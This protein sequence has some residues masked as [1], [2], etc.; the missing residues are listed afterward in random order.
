[1]KIE[2]VAV[3]A[4]R[5]IDPA[6][7]AIVPPIQ[8]S[9]TYQRD[10]DGGYSRSFSYTRPDNPTRHALETC[11]A[12]LEG[13]TEA[14]CF[15]SGAAATMAVF[16]LLNPGDHVLA[17]QECYY[18]TRQ[19]LRDYLSRSGVRA[20]FI[21]MSDPA[22]LEARLKPETRLIW[23]ETPCNPTLKL[24]DL[25]V[26][27]RC[28]HSVGALLVCDNTF[29]T[30]VLQQPLAAGA[31]AVVHSSTKYFGGHSDV[32]GGAVIVNDAARA[33]AVRAYQ[34]VGGAVPSPF[35]CWLIRR[36][37]A[38][39]PLRIRTQSA[40]ALE[41]AKFLHGHSRVERVCYPGLTDDPGH[42]LALRQ[43]TGFGAMVSVCVRGDARAAMAVAA[44]T[45]VFTC[46][47]SLGGV[48][49]L[50]EH[51]A[52]VE[53]PDTLTPQNLLR[54]SIGLENPQDLIEDLDQALKG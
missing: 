31:D 53:G 27:A 30:P 19:L 22:Q 16:S 4:G 23:I 44:R 40:S 8:M 29:P 7:G 36:S 37:L 43:M 25:K 13:G 52:S 35:D 26:A 33:T 11:I 54:L 48:E 17:P 45:R 12:Q 24:T 5:E 32:M 28:A 18:G 9:T 51:R 50:V 41:V 6:T 34:A 47:T 2:T 46:A 10:A 39:L 21:D 15:S 20:E 42:A 1:M 3:H 49:S 38:T 14:V